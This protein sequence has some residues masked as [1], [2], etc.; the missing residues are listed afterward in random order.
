MKISIS[1]KEMLLLVLFFVFSA[2]LMWRTF[3]LTPDGNIAIGSRLWSDFA[4]TI[5]LIRSFSLGDNFPP[6]YPIFAGPHIKYHFVFYFFVGVLEKVGLPIDWSLNVPSTIG[7]FVLLVVIYLLAKNLFDSKKAGVLSVIF[8]LL[9]G[10]LGFIAFFKNHPN[11]LRNPLQIFANTDFTSFGPYDGSIVSAFWN[12]NI[13]TNQRHLAFSYA[14]FL[15]LVFL[16]YGLTAKDFSLKKAI[17]IGMF[18]GFFPFIHM[19]VF[20]MMGLLLLVSF[21]LF[22]KIRKK[23]LISGIIALTLAVPQ[24]LYMGSINTDTKLFNP[25]Y[26]VNKDTLSAFFNYWWLNLGLIFPLSI[27]GF[28]LSQK[29]KKKVYFVFFSLFLVGNL[30]QFT[31]EV[32]ANHKFFNLFLIGINMFAG[33]AILR[34]WQKNAFAK[35]IVIIIF[36]FLILTG[37]IDFF[38][39]INDRAIVLEDIPNNKTAAFIQKNTA[40]DAVFLNSSYLYHPAS[41]AG[42]KIFMGW[43]YFAWSAGYNTHERGQMM[44]QFFTSTDKNEQCKILKENRIDYFTIQDTSN[45]PNIANIDLLYFRNNFIYLYQKNDF[46]IVETSRNC[47]YL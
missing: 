5:P 7:F 19:A 34:L 36:P 39:V 29:K 24:Y 1:K 46:A 15:F 11:L 17:F 38:P 28:F 23:I 2:F 14:S 6:Q 25:G 3:Y 41:V 35:A 43:P 13:Y 21:L 8:F 9:N 10:S 42:R 16:L 45:D 20:G 22:P 26:L 31:P 47:K 12:L 30:F 32:A 27:V 37:F 33:Y 4:A 44:D 18:V 40:K